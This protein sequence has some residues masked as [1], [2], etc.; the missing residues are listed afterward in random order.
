MTDTRMTR[1]DV[2]LRITV[3]VLTFR[4]PLDLAHGL[5]LVIDQASGLAER[6]GRRFATTVLVVDND[7]EGSAFRTVQAVRERMTDPSVSLRYVVESKPGIPPAR[8]RAIDESAD[9]DLLAFIDDDERPDEHWLDSLVSTWLRTRA[10]AVTGRV[11]SEFDGELDEWVRAGQFFTRR[12]LP[13]GTRVRVGATSNLLLD[14]RRIAE[15][16]VRFDTTLR[17]GAGEDSLFCLE[18]GNRGG[19]IVWCQESIA[20]DRVP[21]ARMSREWVLERARSHGN[22]EVV[23]DLRLVAGRSRQLVARGKAIARGATR[24][25]AGNARFAFGLA[26]GSLRHQARGLRTARRGAGMAAGG[27]GVAYQEYARD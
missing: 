25:A 19:E 24:V 15:T 1:A 23:V 7:P 20:I 3:A 11:V 27:V 8:N 16:G 26:T 10:A 21:R 22:A 14:C 12:S 18:L 2:A 13:T 4:R 5:P 6:V 9:D 17:F